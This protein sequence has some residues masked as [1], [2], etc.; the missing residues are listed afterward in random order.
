MGSTVFPKGMAA[1]NVIVI[2]LLLKGI[3]LC[4][5]ISAFRMGFTNALMSESMI[6]WFG[7]AL[8]WDIR[9]LP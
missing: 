7:I 3:S 2:Y 4:L 9:R 8:I 5:P 6:I 1:A